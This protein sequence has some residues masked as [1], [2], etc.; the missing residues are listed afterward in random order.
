MV[1]K[2]TCGDDLNVFSLFNQA[3]SAYGGI[4]QV[5]VTAGVFVPPDKLGT[6][7]APFGR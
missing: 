2:A 5:V 7:E 6:K 1:N 4:D 3:I